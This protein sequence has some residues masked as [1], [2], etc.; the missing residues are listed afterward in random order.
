MAAEEGGSSVYRVHFSYYK[1]YMANYLY[2][3]HCL[4]LSVSNYFIKGQKNSSLGGIYNRC[5]EIVV[6]VSV[7]LPNDGAMQM[8]EAKNTAFFLLI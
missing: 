6:I 5:D 1:G 8:F 7:H 4:F 3:Q 2:S